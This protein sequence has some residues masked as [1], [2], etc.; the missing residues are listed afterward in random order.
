MLILIRILVFL[1]YVDEGGKSLT[2]YAD[3]KM[4][5]PFE[6]V[7]GWFFEP[8][9]KVRP[10]DL[11]FFLILLS[12][13][14]RVRVK[15]MKNMLLLAVATTLTWF[16]LGVILRGGDMKGGS[17]Q[18]YMMVIAPMFAFAIAA[19]H[20]KAI[21]Y[22]QLAVV[23]IAAG[24]YR[25]IMCLIFYFGYVRGGNVYFQVLT[26]H[27]DTVL[28]VSCIALLTVN[29]LER[30]N[31]AA[32]AA[33][34]VIIPLL[35]PAIHFNNRRLAWLSLATSMVAL[36][37]AM[38]ASAAKRRL[39]RWGVLLLPVVGLYVAVGWGR[40]EKIFKPLA[41]FTSVSSTPDASALARNV[42]NLGLIATASYS[43]RSGTGWGHK[44]VEISNK[45]SI[46]D[47]M[48]LW[49]YVPHNSILGLFAFT[50]VIGMIG[51]WLVFPTTFFFHARTARLA[52]DPLHRS[53]GLAGVMVSLT[54]VNQM[55]GDMGIFS[56]VTMYT[57]GI[58]WAAALRIPAEA[59][60]WPGN[61]PPLGVATAPAA[62][63]SQSA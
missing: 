17:W 27:Y 5:T 50:G 6:W 51:Y 34:F 53:I 11:I 41:S 54:C 25:A 15:P 10:F 43:P 40:T 1:M 26:N 49:Q 62:A 28:W 24:V 58:S 29:F 42:E 4:F 33:A 55:F 45:Y 30:R 14:A 9:A 18:V 13:G 20:T 21:H 44:Y 60:V 63:P 32:K 23:I 2:V 36:F 38:P 8:I 56:P 22:R 7:N 47:L 37:L 48:E 57:M 52:R 39:K 61:P 46:A 12:A 3:S 35:L 19:T 16:V 59:G 31:T